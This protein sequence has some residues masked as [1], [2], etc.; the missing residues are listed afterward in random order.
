MAGLILSWDS[1]AIRIRQKQEIGK[2]E[3][4]TER[5]K[6]NSRVHQGY[7]TGLSWRRLF[8]LV[9]FLGGVLDLMT[10]IPQ[11]CEHWALEFAHMEF[12]RHER[13]IHGYPSDDPPR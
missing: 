3:C 11:R 8:R 6:G 13:T 7:R 12:Y 10:M 5:L 9:S 1:R 2:K 4:P